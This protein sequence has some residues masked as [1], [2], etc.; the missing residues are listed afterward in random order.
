MRTPDCRSSIRIYDGGEGS[1]WSKNMTQ[2]RKSRATAGKRFSI[3][4][5]T[6]WLAHDLGTLCE[7]SWVFGS[8]FDSCSSKPDTCSSKLP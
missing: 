1:S 4:I 6:A 2:A 3:L 5:P 8:K 7:G